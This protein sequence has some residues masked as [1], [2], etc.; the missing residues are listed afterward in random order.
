MLFRSEKR[1]LIP[2]PKVPT[3]D[4]KPEMSAYEVTEAIVK[5]LQKAE[6]DFVCLN[7]ANSDMV[8][9]TGVYEAVMKAVETVDTCVGKVVEAGLENGY[10]FIIFADHGNADFMTNDDGS[11]N[12]AHSTNPVPCI[13]IDSEYKHIK[14][15]ILADIAP[16]VLTIMGMEIPGE[17]TGKAL[18]DM[19]LSTLLK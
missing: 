8:G 19:G 4:L 17:M 13:L 15:G 7:Y 10:S 3:Y 14:N 9:H 16:T 11:P 2:S 12:T 18:V 1:I 5:E 6:A